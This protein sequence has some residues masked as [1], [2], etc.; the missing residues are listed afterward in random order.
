M[1][2]S[3]R[4]TWH[5]LSEADTIHFYKVGDEVEFSGV[6]RIVAVHEDEVDVTGY[7]STTTETTPGELTVTL[8]PQS[9]S[10]RAMSQ[11]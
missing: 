2:I 6:A 7:M 3:I 9:I 4:D 10:F 5:S 1:R 8:S 11:A